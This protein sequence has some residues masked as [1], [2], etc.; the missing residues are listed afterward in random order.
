[1][2]KMIQILMSS[3]SSLWEIPAS[4]IADD[5]GKH[6]MKQ[7]GDID[8]GY[9]RERTERYHIAYYEILEDDERLKRWM[10]QMDWNTLS[11]HI[12]LAG[13]KSFQNYRY[14]F[15]GA[16]KFVVDRI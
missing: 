11:N 4:V 3:D 7:E 10:L 8:K 5:W 9:A 13:L 6:V 1:M 15:E 12:Q 14:E 2:V 16:P